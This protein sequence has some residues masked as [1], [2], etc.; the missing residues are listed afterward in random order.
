MQITSSTYFIIILVSSTFQYKIEKLCEKKQP[1][2]VLN[3]KSGGDFKL[4]IQQF[5]FTG[6]SFYEVSSAISH[7][8]LLT[9]VYPGKEVETAEREVEIY[10]RLNELD[11]KIASRLELCSLEY[12]AKGQIDKIFIF[13]QTGFSTLQMFYKK[14]V[15]SSLISSRLKLYVTLAQKV[16]KLHKMQ[17]VHCNLT[18]ENIISPQAVV[19]SLLLRDFGSAVDLKQGSLI[20]PKKV[21]IPYSKDI[22]LM[23]CRTRKFAKKADVWSMGMFILQSEMTVLHMGE[24]SNQFISDRDDFVSIKCYQGSWTKACDDSL[25]ALIDAVFDEHSRR[26]KSIEDRYLINSFKSVVKAAF[27]SCKNRPTAEEFMTQLSELAFPVTVGPPEEE[28]G[29]NDE[30]SFTKMINN[31]FDKG[32]CQNVPKKEPEIRY[33]I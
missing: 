32:C 3:E 5:S 13:L 8:Q 11:H 12:T 6:N 2:K 33:I 31:W 30:W 20:C 4:S 21:G 16:T 23:E 10:K 24:M 7:D 27:K 17:I 25:A 19:S 15:R 9:K 26:T 22:D 14:Y 1:L 18:P 28:E 29:V